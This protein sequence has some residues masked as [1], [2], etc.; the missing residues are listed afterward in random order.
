MRKL[1]KE[2]KQTIRWHGTEDTELLNNFSLFPN[3]PRFSVGVIEEIYREDS[4]QARRHTEPTG[5][6]KVASTAEKTEMIC[7]WRTCILQHL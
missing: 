2:R 3:F 6:Q 1:E 4:K 7:R 5:N